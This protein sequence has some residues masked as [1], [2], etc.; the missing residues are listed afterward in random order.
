[1]TEVRAISR[2]RI[3][4]GVL[5]LIVVFLAVVGC[6]VNKSAALSDSSSTPEVL[7][8]P[9]KTFYVVAYHYG[10]VV[11]DENG[12]ELDAIRVKQG[13]TVEIYAVNYLAKDAIAKLPAAVKGAIVKLSAPSQEVVKAFEPLYHGQD[14]RNHGFLIHLY[15]VV[16]ILYYDAAE[17]VRVVFMAK[18]PGDYQFV[19]SEYCGP[20][21]QGMTRY[22]LFVE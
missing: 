3:F 22:L 11:Y 5:L 15:H 16:E 21:H 6:V 1:M 2:Q 20:G 14:P 10:W 13:T 8:P 4:G 7:P 19:C 18:Y 12:T 17:P 9:D